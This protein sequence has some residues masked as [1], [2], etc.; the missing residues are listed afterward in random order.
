LFHRLTTFFRPCQNSLDTFVFTPENISLHDDAFQGAD[1]LH[2][3]EWWY[4][5]ALLTQGYSLQI[6]FQIISL[7]DQTVAVGKI[8]IYQDGSLVESKEKIYFPH[9]FTVSTEKPLI[10]LAGKPVMTGLIDQNRLRYEVV[11]AI[12]DVAVALS[13]VGRTKG[14]KGSVPVGEWI[15]TQPKADVTGTLTIRDSTSEVT[16]VGYHD[17]N[18]DI[19]VQAR[20][21]YLG[22]Y[23]GKI[24]TKTVTATW[25]VLFETILDTDPLLVIN[26]GSQDY[27][28]IAPE[29]IMFQATDFSFENGKYIPH[30][31]LLRATSTQFSLDLTMSVENLHHIN[32]G[33]LQYWRYHVRCQGRI[34]VGSQVE[35]VDDIQI[36]EFLRFR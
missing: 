15:V 9:E 12:D 35:L 2:F 30:R 13:F 18:T 10:T 16:G 8:N 23:W 27:R 32:A 4:F 19:T 31:F 28:S 26:I 22:W 1:T 33:I 6:L 3:T 11:L 25:S 20:Y 21:T 17:H 34:S 14:W 36:N 5:D 7:I 24:D 29:D